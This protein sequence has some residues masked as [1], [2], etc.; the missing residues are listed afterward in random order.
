[1]YINTKRIHFRM[2]TFLSLR[3]YKSEDPFKHERSTTLLL[4]RDHPKKID[5][6]DAKECVVNKI[7]KDC[8]NHVHITHF[9]N[10]TS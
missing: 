4:E 8:K 5:K 6:Q 10:A 1:M 9:E 3:E 7:S 2:P